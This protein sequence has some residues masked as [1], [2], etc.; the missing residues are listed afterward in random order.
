MESDAGRISVPLSPEA[1][2]LGATEVQKGA[3]QGMRSS[4]REEGRGTRLAVAG[5]H[6][7]KSGKCGVREQGFNSA[8]IANLL[9]QN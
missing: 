7:G 6:E 3:R 8:A 5:G 9:L 1:S 2:L 4:G